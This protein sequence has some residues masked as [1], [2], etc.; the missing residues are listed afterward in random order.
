VRVNVSLYQVRPPE[1]LHR[2]T[3]ALRYIEQ[4]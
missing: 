2:L 4:T 3:E 1:I